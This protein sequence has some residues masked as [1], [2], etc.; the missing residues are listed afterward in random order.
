MEK[1][2]SLKEKTNSL[3]QHEDIVLKTAMREFSKVLLP[4]LG[5]TEKVVGYGPTENIYLE[6]KKMFQDFTLI[7]ENGTWKHFEFQSTNE[8]IDG[9]KR[10]RMYEAVTSYQHKVSVT[11]YVLFSGNILNPVAEYTEGVNTYRIIPII[12]RDQNADRLFSRL[13]QKLKEGQF[14][15]RKIW[16]R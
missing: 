8:G 13:Q 5:I 9:L 14:S 3:E 7:M 4:W 10:F 6:A 1:H 16:F 2:D 11:T 12:M 15:Q